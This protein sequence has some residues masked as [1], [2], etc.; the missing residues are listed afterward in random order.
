MAE[1][2]SRRNPDADMRSEDANWDDSDAD[3]VEVRAF[4][5]PLNAALS[6]EETRQGAATGASCCSGL[7]AHR[8]STQ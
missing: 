2:L 7:C 4:G 6:L 5:L 8:Q 1:V 3:T